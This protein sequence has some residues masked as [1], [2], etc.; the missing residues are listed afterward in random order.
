[1]NIKKFLNYLISIP[2]TLYINFAL[3]PLSE[4]IKIP[5]FVSWRCQIKEL[6]KGAIII[7][8]DEIKSGILRI[9]FGGTE[10]IQPIIN[11]SFLQIS[12]SGK[13]ILNGKVSFAEGCTIRVG[14][15]LSIGKGC[16][17]NKYVLI[18]CN[19]KITIGDDLLCGWN[20]NFRDTDNHQITCQGFVLKDSHELEIGNHVWICAYV[21]LI[22]GKVP[23]NCVV[24]YRSLI[25][26]SF[27]EQNVLL[28]GIP[29]NIVKTDINWQR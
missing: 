22:K 1:M 21:D 5:V 16:T 19:N 4:A 24:G 27:Y 12:Q 9:G 29:A 8:R 2:K 6:H 7:N 17:F 13:I 10:G 28:A 15:I 20:V 11:K 26:K 25:N 3:F 18:S 14:G 23:D